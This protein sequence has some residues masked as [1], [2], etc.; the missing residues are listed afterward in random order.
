MQRENER[1]Y[2][3]VLILADIIISI[4][5]FFA[6]YYIK[7]FDDVVIKTVKHQY[8]LLGLLIIPVW[9]VLLKIISIQTTQRV[10]AYSIIFIEYFL[11]IIIGIS[12]LFIF[13]FTFKLN[14]ISRI[15]ILVFGILNL[16]LLSAIKILIVK[17]NKN[18]FIKGKNVKNIIIIADEESIT[19]IEKLVSEKYWGF[20]IFGIYSDSEII[21]NKYCDRFLI[22]N[23]EEKLYNTIEKQIIDEVI[24]CKNDINKEQI[25]KLIF[26]CGEI[27]ITL[28]L[29]SELFS[30][31]AS[32]SNLNYMG[33]FPI[34]TFEVTSADY[35]ALKIKT[36]FEYIFSLLAVLV[37]T[38]VFLII[39]ILIK[40]ESKG[41]VFFKQ[42][43]VGLHGRTFTMLK[44]RTMQENA[45][46][47][48]KD[49]LTMNEVDGPV[50]KIK[51]DPR[52]TKIGSFLRKTSLD[53]FPQFFNVLQGDMALVGPRPPV[54][55][56]VAL[57]ERHQLR[58]LSMK[59]GITCIW[60][61]SER[62]NF[63]FEEWIKLDLQY[64]DNWSLKLDFILILKTINAIF[65]R[66]GY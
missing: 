23:E 28:Q 12:I 25:K 61:A 40:S 37:F 24:Y 64:I 18:L 48:K 42:K 52:I 1:L 43:R 32:K 46:E 50:F 26:I 9:Y 2:N 53:E 56:E 4:L 45:E 21:N 33:D 38:P 10:K 60:Q 35:F 63:S 51:N 27:G 17:Y 65:K 59:P 15:V 49:L 30:T 19:F 39:A 44:F 36:I 22:I 57:Y 31:I 13:I 20:N 7:V 3:N 58:R 54:P 34:I 41:P 16:F 62:N 6:A 11:T 47:L 8:I 55:E 66:T 14:F 29:Q 5:T